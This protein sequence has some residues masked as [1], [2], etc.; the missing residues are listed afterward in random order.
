MTERGR[1]ISDDPWG[2]IAALGSSIRHGGDG[3]ELT[4]QLLRQVLDDERWREFES[5]RRLERNESFAEFV[6]ARPPQGLCTTPERLRR[7]VADDPEMSRQI[8]T[9]L[10]GAPMVLLRA[11][12]PENMAA[13]L[14]ARLDAETIRALAAELAEGG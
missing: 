13:E 3:L 2:P 10:P 4:P 9:T 8:D 12:T 6:A 5:P 11:T 1:R 7:M 14:R